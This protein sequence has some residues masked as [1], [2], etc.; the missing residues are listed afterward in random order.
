M[1]SLLGHIESFSSELGE[2]SSW[3]DRLN[4][5]FEYSDF[6]NDRKVALFITSMGTE[7][8]N[9]NQRSLQSP[10]YARRNLQS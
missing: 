2:C 9:I 7:T 3:L 8:Y 5:L 4:S 6:P 10:K 1:L